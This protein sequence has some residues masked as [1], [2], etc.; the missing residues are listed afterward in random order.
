M[1]IVGVVVIDRDPFQLC[2]E[3]AFHLANQLA[4]VLAKI[5]AIGIFGRND[6]PPHEFRRSSPSL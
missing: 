3:V 2:V 4:N 1:R 6:K 5:E